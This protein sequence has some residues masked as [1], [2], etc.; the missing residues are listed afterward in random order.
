MTP[1]LLRCV[2][3]SGIATFFVAITVRLLGKRTPNFHRLL[4][5]E[6]VLLGLCV[7]P[8]TLSIP[9]YDAPTVPENVASWSVGAS[10]A[11]YPRETPA[12]TPRAPIENANEETSMTVQGLRKNPSLTLRALMPSLAQVW[13]AG[14][15][16][17]L[18]RR[19]YQ[20]VR[21]HLRLRELNDE[22]PSLWDHAGCGVPAKWGWTENL[23]PALVLSWSGYR[24]LFPR[25]LWD[26]LSESQRL[27]ILQHEIAHYRGG[28]VYLCELARLLVIP[29]WFNP[30]AWFA[31][32]KFD[33][34]TEW[35]CDDQACTNPKELIET[36]LSVHDSTESLGLYLSSFARINVMTRI[37]RL[38]D[39]D[40]D[41]KENH[42]MKKTLIL[43]LSFALLFCGLFQIKLVAKQQSPH[44]PGAVPPTTAD[45]TPKEHPEMEARIKLA[46]SMVDVPDITTARL[47]DMLTDLDRDF[48][49][50]RVENQEYYKSLEKRIL[51]A[52]VVVCDKILT[53]NPD[54]SVNPDTNSVSFALGE[55]YS[56]LLYLASANGF[57]E[58][59]NAAL[60]QYI[61]ECRKWD[62]PDR[63]GIQSKIRMAKS[64]VIGQK[65]WR[66]EK[67]EKPTWEQFEPVKNEVLEFLK[68]E[69]DPNSY[70]AVYLITCAER[71]Q[72]AKTITREQLIKVYDQVIETFSEMK[73]EFDRELFTRF[74]NLR[75]VHLLVGQKMSSF[76]MLSPPGSALFSNNNQIMVQETEVTELPPAPKKPMLIA[77]SLM[78]YGAS[79]L[80]EYFRIFEEYKDKDPLCFL[81]TPLRGSGPENYSNTDLEWLR[82]ATSRSKNITCWTG[83][84][85]YL[86]NANLRPVA[87]NFSRD[88]YKPWNKAFLLIDDTGTIVEFGTADAIRDKLVELYGQPDVAKVA[89]GKR[90][91]EEFARMPKPCTA[92]MYRIVVAMHQ[93]HDT[94]GS[95]PPAYTVD[96][97]GNKLHSWRTLLL[98]FLEQNA[99]YKNIRLDEPWNSEHNKRFGDLIVP[100]FL[101]HELA[102]EKDPKPVTGYSVVVGPQTIFPENGKT[103]SFREIT[104]GTSNTIALVERATPIPWM[105]PDDVSFD[106]AVKGIGVTKDGIGDVH[107]GGCNI[108]F[109]DGS[110]HFVQKTLDL[111]ILRALLTKS[112]GE[113]VALP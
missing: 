60:K 62:A 70:M 45:T 53:L 30:F 108:T 93:Y 91:A 54:V 14:I 102:F 37:N 94:Y 36:L 33:E 51:N 74:E 101:C 40:P 66:L 76:K 107:D 35:K 86:N 29:Q 16:V 20:F 67:I 18:L 22:A 68:I 96:A 42:T 71:M 9:Y 31:A 4:W 109:A 44:E 6:A 65:I 26:E 24:L 2:I 8:W 64:A 25:A 78:V 84:D 82:H 27:G 57:T 19:V 39:F 12:L 88:D 75:A 47:T 61:E 105:Q 110:V 80:G 50:L 32:R 58:A 38:V 98:P 5:F 81:Y 28:D 104:D 69:E 87:E 11:R 83:G 59:D 73:V 3:L 63:L 112:G 48:R 85:F 34:A 7:I 55:K 79:E 89:E 106:E 41:T 97:D 10:P 77:C 17:L 103:N 13:L 92:N 52:K 43:L 15:A 113:S 72:D 90:Q 23:G 46:E 99:L 21:L 95:F 49:K 100:V 56:T 111:K 1:F